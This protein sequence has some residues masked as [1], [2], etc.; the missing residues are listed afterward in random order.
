MGTFDDEYQRRPAQTWNLAKPARPF[1]RLRSLTRSSLVLQMQ[2]FD[3]DQRLTETIDMDCNGYLAS[4]LPRRHLA[5]KYAHASQHEAH[6]P[7]FMWTR[8]VHHES[9]RSDRENSDS[10]DIGADVLSGPTV[11]SLSRPATVSYSTT[12]PVVTVAMKTGLKTASES[13]EWRFCA[14]ENCITMV[15]TTKG[16]HGV[17]AKS[18][19]AATWKPR[20]HNQVSEDVLLA[21]GLPRH[22]LTVFLDLHLAGDSAI[23]LGEGQRQ[24]NRCTCHKARLG[25]I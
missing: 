10:W 4:L 18:I 16:D 1:S 13:P 21:C 11:A 22:W 25:H 7:Q 14:G 9:A 8:D 20:R 6:L 5:Q 2:R 19:L 24:S 17:Y 15:P 3:I 12:T 23:R